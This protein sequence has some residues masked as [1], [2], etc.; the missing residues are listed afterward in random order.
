MW[1]LNTA[2]AELE[3]FSDPENVPGGYAI[4][5]HVWDKHED[6]FQDIQALRARC[7]EDGTNP[8]DLASE[9]VRNFCIL[10]ERDGYKWGW[11]DTCCV[12]KTSSSDLSEAIT[13]M[14][15][16]YSLADVCYAYLS[17]VPTNCDLDAPDS[18]FRK[19][20]WHQ[21]GWTLQEL[22]APP[23][24]ILLSM[25]WKPLGSK[26]D[27][28]RLLEEITR[29][30]QEVLNSKDTPSSRCVAERM[31]WASNR[32]TTRPEDEAYCLMGLFGIYMPPLYGEGKN[33]FLR[34]QE[35]I[36]YNELDRRPTFAIT[37]YALEA[38]APV[39]I[40]L[41]DFTK[42]I[43]VI[44]WGT[45]L[46]L[47]G[48]PPEHLGV[49]LFDSHRWGS[50][51][52]TRQ[53]YMPASRRSTLASERLFTLPC[54]Y[55]SD[56]SFT[57]SQNKVEWKTVY[58]DHAPPTTEPLDLRL[59]TRSIHTP[60]HIP[61]SHIMELLRSPDVISCE[62]QDNAN[63]GGRKGTMKLTFTIQRAGS[64]VRFY[65]AVYLGLC[66]RAS[67]SN[68]RHWAR[69]TQSSFHSYA[70]AEEPEH[71]CAEH[72]VDEWGDQGRAFTIRPRWSD[73]LQQLSVTL[74]FEPYALNPAR[75][76]KVHVSFNVPRSPPV[77]E[78]PKSGESDGVSRRC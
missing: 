54:E 61:R 38:Y 72:H 65:I 66:P 26:V 60:F 39:V 56:H 25:T 14:Y 62:L 28:A 73:V 67:E 69:A 42:L 64:N 29:I 74:S 7:A 70:D 35:E 71:N 2:R 31:A 3:F 30:P 52:H 55:D 41:L 48:R 24:V 63:N 32:E 11:D 40:P 57:V 23:L 20:R 33:A 8:R 34:L 19:S 53:L 47:P 36:H 22:I 18:A 77:A 50:S 15:R 46:R 27:L 58:V 75:V 37:P 16:Y 17:D 21:R 10:A 49:M 45:E 4:L 76:R 9:K 12:D 78:L 6:S 44:L 13:A 68:P 43:V 51:D 59:L 5:S 1:L